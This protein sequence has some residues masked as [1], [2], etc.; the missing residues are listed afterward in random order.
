MLSYALMRAAVKPLQWI[1]IPSTVLHPERLP[2]DRP[3]ILAPTHISHLEPMVLGLILREQVRYMARIEFYRFG[4]YAWVLN[5][6]GAF[7]VRRNGYARPTIRKALELLERGDHIGVFPEAGVSRRQYSAMR[8]GPIKY[9]AC[10]ISMYSGAPIVPV[11]IVG[12]H[13]MSRVGPWLPFRRA[14]VHLAI[15]EAIC[16][17]PLPS[18]LSDRRAA[19]LALGEQMRDQYQRLY[20]ELLQLPGVD[21]RHDLHPN[22]PDDPERVAIDPDSAAGVMRRRASVPPASRADV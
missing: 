19:R 16:P 22:Q 8:G 15:G 14:P 18:R 9:G 2:K 12:T 11:A 21:D 7:P 10:F 4:L 13:A 20:Q 5:R 17:G 1:C 6:S 3:C